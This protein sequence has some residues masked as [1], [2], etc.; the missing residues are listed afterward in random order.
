MMVFALMVKTLTN[1]VPTTY[2]MINTHINGTIGD[3]TWSSTISQFSIKMNAS[4]V[5]MVAMHILPSVKNMFPIPDKKLNFAEFLR[6]SMKALSAEGQK[7]L[8]VIAICI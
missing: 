3:C 5:V 7:G 1:I 2:E 8:L 6:I 4:S